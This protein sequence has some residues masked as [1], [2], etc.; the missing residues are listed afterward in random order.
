MM[1]C[2]TGPGIVCLYNSPTV[3][4]DL[5]EYKILS[6]LLVSFLARHRPTSMLLGLMNNS[7]QRLVCMLH[8][9]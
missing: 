2:R 9:M 6:L 3:S 5:I 7:M 8:E 4:A 1:L